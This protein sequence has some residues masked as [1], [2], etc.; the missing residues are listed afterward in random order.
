MPTGV[1]R[2]G[3][4]DAGSAVPAY[5]FV[6]VSVVSPPRPVSAEVALRLE[7]AD[8]GLRATDPS[9]YPVSP[10]VLKRVITQDLGL[11]GLG[12]N[13]PHRKSWILQAHRALQLLE[14]DEL[15]LTTF[16]GLPDH[17]LLIARPEDEELERLTLEA[18]CLRYWRMLFHLRV[19]RALDSAVEVGSLTEP[20][21]RRHVEEIGQVEFDEIDVMLRRE[22]YL[23]PDHTRTMG[24][25]EF[26][27]VYL[28]LNHF[29]PDWIPAYFP[30]LDQFETVNE[31]LK[32]YVDGGRLVDQTRV[33]GAPES[34]LTKQSADP[35]QTPNWW[36]DDD[37]KPRGPQSYHTLG[38][39]AR[40]SSSRGNNARAARLWLQA[41]YHSPSLLAGDAVVN[42][43]REVEQLTRRLQAALRFDDA[44]ADEWADALF[45]LLAAARP[46]FWNQDAGCCMTCSASRWIMNGKCLSS[47]RGNG[48]VRLGSDRCVADCR[49]SAKC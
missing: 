30:G 1:D 48:C 3:D 27:A 35:D 42:A 40:K 25:V 44:R 14:P 39:R 2:K 28:E 22:K 21:V 13:L 10:R 16:E 46:G 43:R 19:H 34:P 4:L 7:R 47:I 38:E 17:V 41:A 36:D 29:Q 31:I 6:I 26:A 18:M 9:A 33:E 45:A 24:F 37:N 11:T 23:P 8:A 20:V 5:R 49:I 12:L 15:G 32:R